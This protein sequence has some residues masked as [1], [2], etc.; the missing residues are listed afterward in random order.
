MKE[1]K[2]GQCQSRMTPDHDPAVSPFIPKQ[3]KIF[4]R[5]SLGSINLPSTGKHKA[6]SCYTCNLGTWGLE[7]EDEEFKVNVGNTELKIRLYDSRV[8]RKREGRSWRDGS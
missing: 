2:E 4:I 7:Q 6:L 3:Q 8:C 5:I 1:V